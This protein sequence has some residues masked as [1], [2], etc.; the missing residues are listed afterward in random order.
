MSLIS[1][2]PQGNKLKK[3]K[4]RLKPTRGT[5]LKEKTFASESLLENF[6]NNLTASEKGCKIP[7]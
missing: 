7:S 6:L 4:A 2:P 3:H 5:T 1:S